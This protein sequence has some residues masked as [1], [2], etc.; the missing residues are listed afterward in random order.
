MKPLTRTA[1][2]GATQPEEPPMATLPVSS[3][4][5]KSAE[6][7]PALVRDVSNRKQQ[8]IDD[9]LTAPSTNVQKVQLELA[10]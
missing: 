7:D 1:L 9:H 6:T 8:F 5:P 3:G 10:K 2:H 4:R